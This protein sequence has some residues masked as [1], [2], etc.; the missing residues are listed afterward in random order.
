MNKT[1]KIP[2]NTLSKGTFKIIF[3]IGIWG[4]E[5][6]IGDSVAVLEFDVVKNGGLGKRFPDDEAMAINGI[7]R[8]DWH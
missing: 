4:T 5:R 3:D 2:A 8:P 7:F 1:F 6:I